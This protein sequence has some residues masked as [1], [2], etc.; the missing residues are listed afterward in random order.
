MNLDNSWR[1]DSPGPM[2]PEAVREFDS[3]IGKIAAQGNRWAILEHFK[4]YFARVSGG[5]TSRSSSEN[6]AASD[7]RDAMERAAENAP[8]FIEAY[9]DGGETLRARDGTSVPDAGRINRI[10]R[11]HGLPYELQPPDLLSVGLH[12]PIAVPERYESL[13]ENAQDI[14]QK[15]LQQSEKLLAEGNHRQAVQEI[16]W[17]MESVVNAFKGLSAGDTTIE[18]KYFNKIVQELRT[19]TKGKSVE[20]V[21]TWLAT[22]HGYLSSPTGGGV[23]HGVDLK[24]GITIDADEGRLYCNLIRS[25]VTFLMAE[26]QRMSRSAR[27]PRHIRS[28]MGAC[29]RPQQSNPFLLLPRAIVSTCSAHQ[30]AIFTRTSQYWAR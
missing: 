6:W 30:S 9:Y 23:R 1:F 29:C 24:A 4:Q 15:S 8:L 16:L 10:L 11:S 25:Y 17:L 2:P 5:T 20:Q 21:L 18:G 26:H 22:L 14:V 12:K 28:I 19:H 13:D 3:L 27:K 7:L